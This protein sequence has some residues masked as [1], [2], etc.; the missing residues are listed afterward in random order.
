MYIACSGIVVRHLDTNEFSQKYFKITI[1]QYFE[2][3]IDI[4]RDIRFFRRETS[5][6]SLHIRKTFYFRKLYS[7]Q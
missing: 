3:F 2:N 4:V 6:Q 1:A 7:K 5:Y